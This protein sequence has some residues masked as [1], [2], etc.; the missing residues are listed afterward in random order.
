MLFIITWTLYSNSEGVV[1]FKLF[2]KDSRCAWLVVTIYKAGW[3]KLIWHSSI[4]FWQ[5]ISMNFISSGYHWDSNWWPK[6]RISIQ[7]LGKLNLYFWFYLVPFID[8]EVINLQNKNCPY[9]PRHFIFLWNI[10]QLWVF[11]IWGTIRSKCFV[12]LL[13]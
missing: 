6:N 7:F 2:L 4:L 5:T 11:A 13:D 12:K 1:L 8:L 3:H 10:T 9:L